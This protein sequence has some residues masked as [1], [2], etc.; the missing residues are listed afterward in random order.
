MADYGE[1]RALGAEAALEAGL[2]DRIATLDAVL[3]ERVTAPRPASA[4]AQ[5]PARQA[6]EAPAPALAAAPG[7]GEDFARRLARHR[8]LTRPAA[9]S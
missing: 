9:E 5:A 2:V 7:P 8:S 3:G 6:A 1:G 4:R